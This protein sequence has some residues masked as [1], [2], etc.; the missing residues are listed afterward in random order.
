M[1]RYLILFTF[2]VTSSC[3]LPIFAQNVA[4]LTPAADLNAPIVDGAA[5]ALQISAGDLLDVNVF[6]TVELSGRL[7]VDEHGTIALPL[8]GDL[9]V[10]GMTLQCSVDVT[11]A[12]KS[13]WAC[14]CRYH[15]TLF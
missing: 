12:T 11:K 3:T 8:G 13:T 6:D 7:R 4:S 10:S 15:A 1:R 14:S 5:H 9:G 2:F